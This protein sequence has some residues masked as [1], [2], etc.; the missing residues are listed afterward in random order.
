MFLAVL[1]TSNSELGPYARY[2]LAR[3]VLR[4]SEGE[5]TGHSTKQMASCFGVSEQVMSASL[6]ALVAS[7]V[8]ICR[9]E[10]LAGK[11]GPASQLYRISP[12]WAKGQPGQYHEAAIAGMLQR[13]RTSVV[14]AP[15]NYPPEIEGEDALVER[16]KARGRAVGKT[17]QSGRLSNVNRLLMAVLLCR[18]DRLGAVRD[19]GLAELSKLTG[20]TGDQASNRI[21]TLQ[22]AGLIRS[23]IPGATSATL[24]RPTKSAYF[25]NLGHPEIAAAWQFLTVIVSQYPWVSK[26]IEGECT[27]WFGAPG[28]TDEAFFRFFHD[29]HGFA[30]ARVFQGRVD[31]Y[32]S[33]LLSAHWCSLN[34][35]PHKQNLDLIEKIRG[36]F[37]PPQSTLNSETE[38]FPDAQESERLVNM[39][40]SAAL[41]KARSIKKAMQLI[42]NMDFNSMDHLILPSRPVLVGCDSAYPFISVLSAPCSLNEEGRC[43]VIDL[44]V[45]DVECFS[46]EQDIPLEGR[47]CYGLLT[48]F[49]GG[50]LVLDVVGE[51]L[52]VRR[53]FN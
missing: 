26:D 15:L 16:A 47:D 46:T 18:A 27:T 20:L 33:S 4:F 35:K 23:Y 44:R 41:R 3:F 39:L 6:R 19:L 34:D 9:S 14:S 10:Q 42:Q 12:E 11:R 24:F 45:S 30:V 53:K 1:M 43:H 2:C 5:S 29:K 36:D 40:Y 37:L 22:A 51:V 31:E 49:L 50:K 17:R 38:N 48:P 52:V 28:R 21:R 7:G 32:A 13:P 8:L 25:L